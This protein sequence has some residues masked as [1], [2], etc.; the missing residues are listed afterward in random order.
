MPQSVSDE[1]MQILKMVEEDK[2]DAKEAMELINALEG[3]E[4]NI[5][6]KNDVKWLKVKVKTVD[7]KVNVNIPVSLVD[8]GLKLATTY[9]SNL[10][11]S[12]SDQIDVKAIIEAVKN[13]DEG[14]IVDVED[15][16]KQTKVEV[17][18]E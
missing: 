14:K 11:K 8:I 4:E 10:N 6:L 7:D 3:N 1:K 5:R 2:I 16:E 9:A 17:Y 13:G 12:E 15:A 18:V